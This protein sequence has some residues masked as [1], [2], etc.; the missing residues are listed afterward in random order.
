M[1]MVSL[2]LPVAI[3]CFPKVWLILLCSKRD[4]KRDKG[5]ELVGGGSVCHLRDLFFPLES[6]QRRAFRSFQIGCLIKQSKIVIHGPHRGVKE[7]DRVMGTLRNVNQTINMDFRSKYPPPLLSPSSYL[8]S[9]C[10]IACYV[11]ALPFNHQCRTTTCIHLAVR[12]KDDF[13]YVDTYAQESHHYGAQEIRG[14]LV[15][16]GWHEKR[17]LPPMTKK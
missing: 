13:A 14:E 2:P 5:G 11:G 9:R 10:W 7:Y 12:L 3:N 6:C 15:R 1:I 17:G 16:D 8:I 4:P